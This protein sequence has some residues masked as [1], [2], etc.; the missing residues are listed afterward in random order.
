MHVGMSHSS[1]VLA[2]QMS[3]LLMLQLLSHGS[4]Q[5]DMLGQYIQWLFIGLTT[6]AQVT[7]NYQCNKGDF[8]ANT[9]FFRAV[10]PAL[11]T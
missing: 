9:S 3:E 7:Q 4:L 5:H 1:P 2:A 11:L 8:E 10:L 6:I